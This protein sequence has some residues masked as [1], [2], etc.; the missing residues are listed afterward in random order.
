MYEM[1]ELVRQKRD[2]DV[3]VDSGMS[4]PDAEKNYLDNAKLL[5]FYGVD[6]HFA[7]V[8]SAYDLMFTIVILDDST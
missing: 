4:A 1:S 7:V 2:I 8:R 6:F 5:A 3:C